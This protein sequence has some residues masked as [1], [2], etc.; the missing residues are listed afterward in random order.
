MIAQE[1]QSTDEYSS[2]AEPLSGHLIL[3]LDFG[4]FRRCSQRGSAAVAQMRRTAGARRATPDAKR[5]ADAFVPTLQ[6]KRAA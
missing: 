3:A 2:C 6:I 4:R 5:R 1:R